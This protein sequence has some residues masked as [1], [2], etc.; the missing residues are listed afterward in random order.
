MPLIGVSIFYD[1]LYM[2]V[3]KELEVENTGRVTLFVRVE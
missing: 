1:V 3:I 2:P